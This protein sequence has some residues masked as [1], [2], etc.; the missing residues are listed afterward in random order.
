MRHKNNFNLGKQDF[1]LNGNDDDYLR[2]TM[3]QRL[4]SL[5]YIRFGISHVYIASFNKL[6]LVHNNNKGKLFKQLI[7]KKNP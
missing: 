4:K 6:K 1:I 5:V 3:L 2:N 7:H